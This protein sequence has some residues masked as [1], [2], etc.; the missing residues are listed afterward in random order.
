[1]KPTSAIKYTGLG[2]FK[3]FLFLSLLFCLQINSACNNSPDEKTSAQS[4][5]ETKATASVLKSS[6]KP[7]PLPTK[8]PTP[9]PNPT[10]T[11]IP[12][13][14]SPKLDLSVKEILSNSNQSMQILKSLL[15]I[16]LLI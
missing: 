4:A 9:T 3:L 10:N 15:V 16:F 1:M 6:Q 2:Y 8:Q 11:P 14:T 7:T 5:T 12:V 13:P